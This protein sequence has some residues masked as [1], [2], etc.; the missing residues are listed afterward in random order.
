MTKEPERY[1]IVRG[2]GEHGS[3]AELWDRTR[4]PGGLVLE[5][6][7]S[8]NGEATL[9]GYGDDVPWSVARRFISEGRGHL[10]RD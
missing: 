1:E 10:G 7:M 4:A 8:E 5:I 6:R 9:T 2:H 3:F